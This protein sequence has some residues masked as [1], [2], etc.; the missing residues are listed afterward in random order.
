MKMDVIEFVN[1]HQKLTQ[2]RP[3][4]GIIIPEMPTQS[5]DKIAMGIIVPLPETASKYKY[6]LSIEAVLIKY[7]YQDF[8]SQS[9]SQPINTR[10]TKGGHI[11]LFDMV[12]VGIPQSSVV[13]VLRCEICYY[14]SI[15][16]NYN[17]SYSACFYEVN[18]KK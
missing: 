10:T 7:F 9:T 18:I 12:E 14:Q 11:D 2:I 3:K 8:P 6:I 1:Q 5:N 17:N 15:C 13:L 4:V 16:K